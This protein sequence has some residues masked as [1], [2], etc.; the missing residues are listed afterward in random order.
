VPWKSRDAAGVYAIATTI[1]RAASGVIVPFSPSFAVPCRAM[2]SNDID[3]LIVFPARSAGRHTLD[4]RV[5]GNDG[6]S[7]YSPWLTLFALEK[8]LSSGFAL[9]T[10]TLRALVALTVWVFAAFRGAALF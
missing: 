1:R 5:R 10:L 7:S 2:L 9:L 3:F 6:F 8:R 4:S